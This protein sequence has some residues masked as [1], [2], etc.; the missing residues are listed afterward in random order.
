MKYAIGLDVGV[1]SVGWAVLELDSF[2]EPVRIERLGSRIFDKA[3]NP[4]D[5]SSLAAP[6]REAR[7][8]RR[9]LRRHRHRLERI[10]GLIVSAGILPRE[11]L[12][13]LY[14]GRLA[15]IYEVR[16]AALD[17]LVTPQD[18]ARILIHL[19]Q[20]RGFKSNRKADDAA[21]KEG[22]K[23]LN[24]V[25]E[26]KKRCAEMGY[27][28][29]GEMFWRDAVFF[30]CKRNKRENYKNTVDRDSVEAE[31][32]LIFAAQRARGA[33]FASE[34]IEQAY[35]DILLSQRSFADGPACGPY[36]G[37]QIEKMRGTCTFEKG[38]PRAAK[39]SYSFQLFN[40]WQHINH[41]R[42]IEGG[43]KRDLTATDR[44]EIFKLAHEK[45]E[46][47]YAQIRKA[48]GLREEEDFVGI[49]YE[50]G[51]R[52]EKEKKTKLK[53]LDAYH[54]IKKCVESKVSKAA[55]E[56]LSPDD[57]DA[58]GEAL[59]VGRSDADISGKLSDAGIAQPVIEALLQIPTFTK[60]G[61]L[62]VT[63]CKKILPFL[64]QGCTY[65][66]ACEQAGYNFRADE[67][68]PKTYLP[69]L[70]IEDKEI[71]SPVVRRAISQTIK[72]VNAIIREM[73][74]S[75]VYVN[76]ELARELSYN[77]DERNKIKKA[78][79]DNA[80][81]NEAAMQQLREYLDS[82][83]GQDLVKYKLW[84]EQDGRCMYS[85]EAIEI[86]RLWEPGYVDVD[87]IV[88]YS[89]C[90]DDRMANKVLVLAR[91]NR[92]KGNRL[93]LQYLQGKKRDEFIV[94]V[95][96]SN[97][98]SAKKNRLLKESIPDEEEW[99]ERN[100]RDTQFISSH[101]YN[102][103]KQNLRFAPFGK[104]KDKK[105]HVT[106]MNGAITSYV[107]KRWGI[108]KVRADGDLHHAVDAVVIACVTRR[109]INRI[110]DFSYY[111]E[112]KD[113]GDFVVDKVTGEVTDRFPAPWPHFLD[114]LTIRLTE[115]ARKLQQQ[116]QDVNFDT[117]AGL[118]L[119]DVKAP[120]V[121]RM[122]NHKV[123]GAAHKETVKSGKREA[124]GYAI[125]TVPLTELKLKNGEID[126]YYN[127]ESDRLLYA[128]LKDRLEACGGDA[129][130]AFEGVGF[131]KPKADGTPG[132][133]VKKVKV[134][135]K[136]SGMV[137]VQ[138]GQGIAAKDNMVRCD[139]FYVPGDGYYFVP[140]YV[141]DT[142]KGELPCIAPV[143]GTDADGRKKQKRM[144]DENFVFSL[145]PNDL[146]RVYSRRTIPLTITNKKSTL[147]PNKAASGEAG[148]FLYYR[149][150]NVH[151]AVMNGII[152]DNT[153]ECNSIGKTMHCIEKYEVDVLG[154][155]RPV[156]REQRKDF[157]NMKK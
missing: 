54:K 63:A 58:I 113:N 91:E 136:T 88:P 109:M 53:D 129:K 110:S 44:A 38:E 39:A 48:L 34:D 51:E 115:D 65:D 40:L 104:D 6:R 12:D 155:I 29:M 27:R 73:G 154:N 146:M 15:D 69:P 72:V 26:N 93:P 24:A 80:A 84:Q 82:P 50:A 9:R 121:S 33:R 100:L 8:A 106:A 25:S 21:D 123:T 56:A 126:N 76:I 102:Y 112:T 98:K 49:R 64:E 128:A 60:F 52:A 95:R 135:E 124:D 141:A 17:K 71:T 47:T 43:E 107:R 2:D 132:P 117:Y 59:T 144:A 46:I 55:F 37:N 22:G 36:S 125:V 14:S 96:N 74:D 150:L 152:H 114:E 148:L 75:P 31:A 139:V 140:V 90:F 3:E 77:F 79:D 138:G 35:L 78:Q 86:G 137:R 156:E 92:Q 97:L 28:T 94:R 61:H 62:S 30:D 153:Y 45:A 68:E 116:L 41:I 118:D 87:H 42:V 147:E 18:F 149:G 23:L 108:K 7:G 11:E 66:K 131:R 133:I 16:T 99:K 20:R 122:S 89:I 143:A 130:K 85:G 13:T 111:K 1:A 32:R 142:V 67:R 83:T 101:L 5:G 10:R 134:K 157:S 151:T 103:I 70:P 145:Y 4:Q 19:A 105:D 81:N 120:F 57:L 127:P 119:S